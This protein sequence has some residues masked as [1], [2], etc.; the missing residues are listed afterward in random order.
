[1]EAG[2]SMEAAKELSSLRQVID[3]GCRFGNWL[4]KRNPYIFHNEINFSDYFLIFSTTLLY[5]FCIN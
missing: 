1:V 5:P 3:D 2:A 4:G